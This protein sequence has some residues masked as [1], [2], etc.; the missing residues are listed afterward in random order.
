MRDGAGIRPNLKKPSVKSSF[1]LLKKGFMRY[2]FY[3]KR[4]FVRSYRMRKTGVLLLILAFAVVNSCKTTEETGETVP[5]PASESLPDQSALNSARVRA[6]QARQRGLDFK[7][8]DHLPGDWE[9][10]EARFIRAAGLPRVSESDFREAAEAYDEA[11]RAFDEVFERV[12]PLYYGAWEAAILKIREELIATGL[13]DRFPEYLLKADMMVVNALDLYDGGDYYA[14]RDTASGALLTY[15]T[16]KAGAGAY[17]ARERI[18]VRNF[19]RRYPSLFAN[20][21][22]AGRLAL[23]GWEADNIAGA[24]AGAEEAERLYRLVLRAGFTETV[25]EIR[26]TASSRRQRALDLKADIASRT[27]YNRAA[28]L[29]NRGEASYQN[30]DFEEAAELFAESDSAFSA[31][32]DSAEEKRRIAEEAIRLAEERM[33]ESD[34]TAK[35]AELILEGGEQ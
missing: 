5:G 24:R 34:E 26:E 19:D 25:G 10:A 29:Y 13:T 4:E 7:A 3:T 2:T 6:E 11:A 15:Q 32:A 23:A 12:V 18:A 16:L 33:I 30:E 9:N 22:D 21:E 28:N 8:P 27:E 35:N 31:A 1:H 14:A 20:A 17:R